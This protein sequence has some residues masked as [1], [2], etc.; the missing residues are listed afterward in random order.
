LGQPQQLIAGEVA[1]ELSQLA[2]RNPETAN[3][4]DPGKFWNRIQYFDV[5]AYVLIYCVGDL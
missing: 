1:A 2:H 5:E 4:I 3:V